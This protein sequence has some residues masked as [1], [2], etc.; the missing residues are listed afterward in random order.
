MM[1]FDIVWK[2]VCCE[3]GSARATTARRQTRASQR[4]ATEH[5]RLASASLQP[6]SVGDEAL[7][8][9][10]PFAARDFGPID[11]SMQEE[12]ITRQS[13]AFS[14]PR[15]PA[16]G[17]LLG[18]RTKRVRSCADCASAALPPGELTGDEAGL[19]EAGRAEREPGQDEQACSSRLRNEKPRASE[20]RVS[21]W[22]LD[23]R[24][25]EILRR[26][27]RK[28]EHRANQPGEQGEGG[29]ST[30]QVSSQSTRRWQARAPLLEGRRPLESGRPLLAGAYHDAEGERGE[31]GR[32]EWRLV[33]GGCAVRQEARRRASKKKTNGYTGQTR[34]RANGE[35]DNK[36]SSV[37][38]FT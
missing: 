17:L 35:R 10:A 19:G 23:S 31:R 38:E 7:P 14:P 15:A 4:P 21:A 2:R 36:T 16:G 1:A 12:S 9:H 26:L 33:A 18:S 13:V 5:S 20:R 22:L 27:V 3:E 25:F 30:A 29:S 8:V 6:P 28:R 37:N 32:L 11:T 24:R 34:E